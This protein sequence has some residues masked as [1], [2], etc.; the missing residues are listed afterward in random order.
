MCGGGLDDGSAGR[1][2]VTQSFG[3]KEERF[4]RAGL[5][6]LLAAAV[7]SLRIPG[8]GGA[9]VGAGADSVG[10]RACVRA[11][12]IVAC[13]LGT[14]EREC[15]SRGTIAAVGREGEEELQLELSTCN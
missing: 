12:E 15:K 3:V 10:L 5:A 8:G 4:R 14:L 2:L 6:C 9:G 13:G 1:Y 7:A 11:C